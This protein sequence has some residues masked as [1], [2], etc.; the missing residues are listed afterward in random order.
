MLL[1]VSNA[2]SEKSDFW[3][4]DSQEPTSFLDAGCGG[5]TTYSTSSA[6]DAP[7]HS[8]CS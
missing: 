5:D 2:K 3:I 7:L 8:F 1:H 6:R 4:L